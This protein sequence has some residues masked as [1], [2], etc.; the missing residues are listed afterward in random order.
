MEKISFKGNPSKTLETILYINSKKAGLGHYHMMKLI[1]LADFIHLNKYGRPITYDKL[2]AMEYG[3][4]PS[5]AYDYYL[6]AEAKG[7]KSSLPFSIRKDGKKRII[8]NVTRQF[9]D[10]Y[11]SESDLEVL[12]SVVQRY[13]DKSF[14]ELYEITH[15]MSAYKSAWENRGNALAIDIDYEDLI[16]DFE[17][18]EDFIKE[19]KCLCRH[20]S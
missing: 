8:N 19:L 5:I 18:K 1:F 13:S 12:D 2:R 16:L 4:V 14:D 20:I 10:K 6:E 11:F 9:D 3:P 17:G 15:A 7:N